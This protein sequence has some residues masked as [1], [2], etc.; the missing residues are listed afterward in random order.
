[1]S[2]ARF[3]DWQPGD[4]VR[5]LCETRDISKPDPLPAGTICRLG[6]LYRIQEGVEVWAI[7]R[8]S[9]LRGAG[10]I[11]LERAF[12]PVQWISAIDTS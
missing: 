10:H 3:T 4:T 7:W 6:R 12:G 1:M 8:G 5:T 11:N 9:E 2:R